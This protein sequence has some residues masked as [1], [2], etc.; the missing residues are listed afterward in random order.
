MDQIGSIG[1][2]KLRRVSP[3]DQQKAATTKK[4]VS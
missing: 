1:A 3:E 2:S 4:T